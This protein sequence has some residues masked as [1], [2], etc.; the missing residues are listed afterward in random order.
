MLDLGRQMRERQGNNSGSSRFCVGDFGDFRVLA[1]RC[2]SPSQ[3]T[4]LADSHNTKLADSQHTK[5]ADSQNTEDTE[6][7]EPTPIR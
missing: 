5:L 3:H 7:T 4:K 6:I 2:C 1:V